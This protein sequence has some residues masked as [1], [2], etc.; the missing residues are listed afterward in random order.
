[1]SYVV[2]A[3]KYRPKDFDEIISQ[4]HISTTLKNAIEE[5]KVAHAYLFC[6]PRGIGKTTTARILAKALNC[7]KGPTPSPCNNCVSCNEINSGISMDVIEIDGAS[8]RGIDEIRQL[9]ENVKFS[10]AHGRYKIYII[11][12]VHML[13][14]EAFNALLKTLEEPPQHV[15]FIF[16]TTHPNKVIATVSSRCQRFDFRRISVRDAVSKLKEIAKNEGIKVDDDTLFSIAAQADG[17]LRDAESMLD[18]LSVFCKG[19][20]KKEAIAHVLG[21]VSDKLLD[22][23]V[24]II[25]KKDTPGILRFIDRILREGKDLSFFLSSIIGHFRNL[26]IAKLCKD[27]AGLIDLAPQAVEKLVNQAEGFSQEEIFYISGIL[28]NTYERIKRAASGRVV[29]EIAMA[30]ITDRASLASLDEMLEKINALQEKIKSEPVSNIITNRP[31]G[32]I[33]RTQEDLPPKPEMPPSHKTENEVKEL[34]SE[35]KAAVDNRNEQEDLNL[36]K[37]QEIWSILLKLIKTRKMSVAS[38]LLEGNI[39]SA[40]EGVLT[41]GFPKDYSLHKEA[42]ERTE[43]S[44]IIENALEELLSQR[45]KVRFITQDFAKAEESD[46]DGGNGR[47][48]AGY[49]APEVLTEPA[50]QSALEIFDGRIVRRNKR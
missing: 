14:Q 35:K 26:M 49:A 48:K 33:R 1:M 3:R 13:T 45:V 11:D 28:L 17:S 40:D 31:D 22:E 34:Q 39:L 20:I 19:E 18:Q 15:K 4:D 41:I 43:N 5:D 29:F 27:P 44:Q 38:Y 9:R 37:V 6:G 23:F 24:E 2:F 16:A 30:K 32:P 50:I 42:L 25:I 21:T 10:P 12:E 7:K 46:R 47:Q 36:S 8:N